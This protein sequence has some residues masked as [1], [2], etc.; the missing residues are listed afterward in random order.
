MNIRVMSRAALFCLML[1]VCLAPAVTAQT[2]TGTVEGKIADQQGAVLPGVN[3]TL[4]GP[5]GS[6]TTVTDTG[7]TFRFVGVTPA[8]YSLKAELTG[9]A[10][11]SQPEVIVGIGKTVLAEFTMKVSGVSESVEVTAASTVDVKS[12]ATHTNISSDLLTLMPIYSSTSTGLLNAAPGINSSS[13]YGAQASY[14]NALL[15][16]GVDTRDPQGGSAWTFFNQN[17]IEEIQIGG[18]GAPAE[19][20]GFTGGIINTVTKSGGNAFS[21]L[22]SM[23]YTNDSLASNNISAEILDAN[24]GLGEAAI[25]KK[26]ADYT[27]QLGGPISKDKAF[28]FGSVQRYSATSDPTGPVAN[29]QDISPRFNLKFTLQPSSTDT[30]VLGTQY[31]SYNVTGR[32]GI[33]ADG[34]GSR[35]A[36]GDGRRAGV[37]LECAVA[38]GDGN[39]HVPGDQVHRLLGLLLSRSDRPVAV[40]I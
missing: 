24:P 26:L 3:V 31:D 22:F 29:S 4:T 18:L 15:M 35:S 28:F 20:G 36:D 1:W 2:Q 38:Q 21:G 9:F 37:G 12:S 10:T 11:E 25:L 39:E 33:L 7:G 8:T 5:R 40:H 13:A 14:G 19:Y 27:V 32:V 30:I 6:Q 17:L 23:R 34:A 16:D